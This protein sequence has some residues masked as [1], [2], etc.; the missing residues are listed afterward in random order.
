MVGKGAGLT[1]QKEALQN[2]TT[3]QMLQED[4][5]ED[6]DH[7]GLALLCPVAIRSHSSLGRTRL[8]SLAWLPQSDT[9]HFTPGYSAW[10][11]RCPKH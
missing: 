4:K 9:E 3:E 2:P 5:E 10:S 1:G 11:Y 7:I 6:L 8:H